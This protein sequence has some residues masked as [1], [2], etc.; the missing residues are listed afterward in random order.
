MTLAEVRQIG[1]VTLLRYVMCTGARRVST[2]QTP[3]S[4]PPRASRFYWAASAL[5]ET[6]NSGLLRPQAD[7]VSFPVSRV[8]P[9]LG[10]PGETWH[11]P[12]N[13]RVLR[14]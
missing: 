10:K 11:S 7:Q 8:K 13:L 3:P 12:M 1:D 2:A 9:R 4:R 6:A 14:A 5:R